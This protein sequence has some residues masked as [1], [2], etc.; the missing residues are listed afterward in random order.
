MLNKRLQHLLKKRPDTLRV[1]TEDGKEVVNVIYDVGQNKI[2][3]ESSDEPLE[4]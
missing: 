4:D 2:I 1:F 3:L